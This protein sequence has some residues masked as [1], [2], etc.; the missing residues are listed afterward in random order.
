MTL[1]GHST[2]NL[3]QTKI[4][5]FC[6]TIISNEMSGE[7]FPFRIW[8]L[9]IL[10]LKIYLFCIYIEQKLQGK[11]EQWYDHQYW[12]SVVKNTYLE[13]EMVS[14]KNIFITVITRTDFITVEEI[15][16][17]NVLNFFQQK[18]CHYCCLSCSSDL[19]INFG[20]PL[21]R[22]FCSL[23]SI[24]A[25]NQHFLSCHDLFILKRYD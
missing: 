7:F 4:F 25:Q 14:V 11:Q 19:N 2:N 12:E 6:S 20:Y 16:L 10:A 21:R 18:H 24:S 22:I 17:E 15:I 9:I 3:S 23:S 13:Y 8:M 1:A 5:H